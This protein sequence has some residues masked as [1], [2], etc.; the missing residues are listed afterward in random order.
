MKIISNSNYDQDDREFLSEFLEILLKNRCPT[1]YYVSSSNIY[2]D[3]PDFS[4]EA[5]S[6]NKTELNVVYHIAGYI[7]ASIIKTQKICSKCIDFTS[8]KKIKR[9]TFN[10]L[11]RIE[12]A[13]KSFFLLTHECFPFSSKWRNFL[14]FI[15]L[16]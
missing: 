5:I 14:D 12:Q 2:N 9:Y 4:E 6:L 11:S 15:F 13:R 10:E 16:I 1:T 8:S 3:I 7:M